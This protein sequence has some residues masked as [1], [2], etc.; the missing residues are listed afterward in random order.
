[1]DDEQLDPMKCSIDEMRDQFESYKL[2]SERNLETYKKLTEEFCLDK[3][4]DQL[5]AEVRQMRLGIRQLQKLQLE[6]T[7]WREPDAIEEMP[8]SMSTVCSEDINSKEVEEQL[9][10]Q[11][12]EE[13]LVISCGSSSCLFEHCRRRVDSQLLLL[14]YLSDHSDED[15]AFLRCRKISKDQRIVIS[16]EARR[17]PL[18]QNQ[19]IGLLAYGRS[20]MEQS[21]LVESDVPVVVLICKTSASAVLKDKLRHENTRDQVF[22]LWLVTPH[23]PH[24]LQLNATLRLCGRNAAVQASTTLAVRP[25]TDSH[26]TYRMTFGMNCT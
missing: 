10:E 16:F 9:E 4:L 15:A 12:K 19:V 7:C 25:V 13:Q 3:D 17:C 24:Q 8:F 1:M 14:H 5:Q 20:L 11:E 26:D 6:L 18:G 22:V 21:G 2:R 23:A